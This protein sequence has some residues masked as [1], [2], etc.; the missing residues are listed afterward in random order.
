ML[1]TGDA[2]GACWFVAKF[3]RG[4]QFCPD[5]FEPWRDA[6]EQTLAGFGGR[7]LRVVRVGGVCPVS[8][9]DCG[10]CGL[11]P[12]GNPR[13]AR[14]LWQNLVELLAKSRGARRRPL[15]QQPGIVPIPGTRKL[16]RLDENN[17]ALALELTAECLG[18]IDRAAAKITLHGERYPEARRKGPASDPAVP[19]QADSCLIISR[20]AP[21]LSPRV[22]DGRRKTSLSCPASL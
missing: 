4:G 8:L 21:T 3:A 5:F 7:D 22:A 15:A 16:N 20:I 17:G 12:I 9:P 10:W 19:D 6:L 13:R 2:D 1:G 11:T 14:R 18:A